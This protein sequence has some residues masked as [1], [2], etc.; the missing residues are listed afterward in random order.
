MAPTREPYASASDITLYLYSQ[1]N[2]LTPEIYSLDATA[3]SSSSNYNFSRQNIFLI[4]GWQGSYTSAANQLINS[5]YSD[6]TDVNTFVVDWSPVSRTLY[7][8]AFANVPTIG[9]Y[10][11]Q[12]IAD[13]Q[14]QF[15]LGAD[16]FT[17][18]GYSLG[19][20]VAGCAGAATNSN[21]LAIYGLDPAGPLYL[22]N[23]TNNRLDP[24]DAQFVHA[25]HTCGGRWG[26]EDNLGTAD[27][28]PNGGRDQPGCTI[29]LTGL[30]AHSRAYRLFAESVRS[31]GFTAWKCDSYSNF[32]SGQCQSND[33]SRLGGVNIDTSA[34]GD[35]YLDTNSEPPY[36]Q[37]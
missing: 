14:T 4:H 20:H 10:L 6:V 24:S 21:I 35:Y 19:A 28:R 17:I 15:G 32:R 36:S 29:E 31:G 37:S 11:G 13:M 23:I 7:T 33:Q 16:K 8:N 26:F 30:C 5:A 2:T 18:V 12:F 27:Y 22:N 3:L 25:I 9:R 34:T 1:S